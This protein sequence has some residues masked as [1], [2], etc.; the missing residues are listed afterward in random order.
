VERYER[1]DVAHITC[2]PTH[3]TERGDSDCLR[4]RAKNTQANDLYNTL[5]KALRRS[6]SG[7]ITSSSPSCLYWTKSSS[8]AGSASGVPPGTPFSPGVGRTTPTRLRL[9]P[10][11][12]AVAALPG[13]VVA[14]LAA[15]ALLGV[16]VFALLGVAA[17]VAAALPTVA[18]L[19]FTAFGSDRSTAVGTAFEAITAVDSGAAALLLAAFVAAGLGCAVVGAAAAAAVAAGA[20]GCRGAACLTTLLPALPA[21]AAFAFGLGFAFAFAG[22]FDCFS[23][24]ADGHRRL[25]VENAAFDKPARMT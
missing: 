5:C 3:R 12:F 13:V 16:A 2:A 25:G 17:F 19:A 14:A 21:A 11:A 1:P 9:T 20:A 10:A 6:P 24:C 18:G 7:P 8:L 15:A 23:T 4:L 22:A